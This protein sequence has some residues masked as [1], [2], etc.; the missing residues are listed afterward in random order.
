MLMSSVQTV[1]F[2]QIF[3]IRLMWL[4][5]ALTIL[6]IFIF[7]VSAILSSRLLHISYHRWWPY[8]HYSLIFS[9]HE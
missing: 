6:G 1:A 9:S 4:Q 8:C 3:P 2:P 5:G 7:T